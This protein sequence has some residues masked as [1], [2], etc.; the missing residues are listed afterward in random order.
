MKYRFSQFFLVFIFFISFFDCESFSQKKPLTHDVYDQWKRVIG[1]AIS[2]NGE[3]LHF[4]VKPQEGDADLKIRSVKSSD[5]ASFF[6]GEDPQ[7]S[8]D[9]KH[10]VFFLK[11]SLDSVKNL[12]RKKTKSEDLPKDTLAILSLSD[13]RLVK[14]ERVKS[15]KMPEKAGNWIAYQLEKKKPTKDTSKVKG[16]PTKEEGDSLGTEVVLRNLASEREWRFKYV[17]E[18]SFSKYGKIFTF[19]STGDDSLMMPGVYSVTLEN[20]TLSPIFRAKGIFK[21][22]ATDENGNT[23]AFIHDSDTTKSR[24]RYYSLFLKQNQQDSALKIIDT[25]NSVIPKGWLLS[26]YASLSFSKNGK[27]LFF[28]VAPKPFLQDTTKLPEEIVSVDV[29]NWNDAKLQPEQNRFITREREKSFRTVY[30]LESNGAQALETPEFETFISASEGDS[31]NGLLL[32][33][34]KYEKRKVWEGYPTRADIYLVNVNTGSKRLITTN[35]RASDLQFSPKGNF[36]IWY[37]VEDQSWV[38][39][40]CATGKKTLLTKNSNPRFFD[41]E[42]DLPESPSPYG[43][44]GWTDDEK[45]ILYDRYDLWQFSTDGK[46]KTR[47]TKGRESKTVY[48]YVCYNSDE[49][50]IPNTTNWILSVFHEPTKSSGYSSLN[51]SSNQLRV[52]TYGNYA[53]SDFKK[54]K[55]GDV[56]TFRKSTVKDYP[57]LQLTDLRFQS[58]QQVSF[59]NPQQAD[60]IWPTVQLVKWKSFSGEMLEGLLY[61]P[62]DFVPTKKYPMI[63]YCY[64]RSSESLHQ[65]SPPAPSASTVN[66][67]LYP[68]NGYVLFIPDIT[69]KVGYPGQSAYDDIISGVKSIVKRGFIDE[70]K[71][72]LQ[73]QSWGGYQTAFLIT[74]TKKMFAAAMAGAPVANMTSA[75]G[76]IRWESGISRMFQYEQSQSRIGATLWQKPNLYLEN[77]PLFSS[78]KIE[79]PLLMMANDADG[80]VPWYQGIEMFM[81]LKR[82]EKPVWMLNYNGEAHNLVQRKNQKDLSVRMMQFFDHYLKGAPMP[83][84]MKTGV[85]AIEKS[86]NTGFEL[87]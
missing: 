7:F 52:L 22:L 34:S 41:E 23:I 13:K 20:E 4:V 27:K 19:I 43:L 15:F 57:D 69:Y 37:S 11:P 62:D 67:S 38:T 73:G 83:R 68:S 65:Y 85:K 54:A 33:E 75:Y 82:L 50:S 61:L 56:V 16:R 46:T 76:G 39:Y 49:R 2:T 21:K 78:E 40:E 86:I 51:P 12:K 14:I 84:W 9:S 74:K 77:S 28:G 80:A 64:D 25:L 53:V 58:I 31:P 6:R 55:E 63:V 87:E 79:T 3:W 26:E 18:F 1:N 72:G 60:F 66:R 59:A 29:W 5:S 10:L 17:T 36:I 44:A 70:T 35:L 47:L 30:L 24:I 42:N 8:Y 71:M 48:R 81:A 45:P 32:S